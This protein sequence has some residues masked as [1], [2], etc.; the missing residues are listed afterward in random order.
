MTPARARKGERPRGGGGSD[1]ASKEGKGK[2]ERRATGGEGIEGSRIRVRVRIRRKR[3]WEEP[4]GRGTPRDAGINVGGKV[5]ALG[6]GRKGGRGAEII[7]A[8]R[9]HERTRGYDTP[10]SS[11][12]RSKR[13]SERAGIGKIIGWTRLS[14]IIY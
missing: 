9:V 13:A 1:S 14:R 4:I 5:G 6:E 2:G 3:D 10:W 12:G 11:E 7:R 8:P